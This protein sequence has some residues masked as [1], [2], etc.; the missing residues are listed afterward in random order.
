MV[1]LYTYRR[2]A[3]GTYELIR[4]NGQVFDTIRGSERDA[5]RAIATDNRILMLSGG[6]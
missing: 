1:R 6:W 3:R 5:K 2:V 4:P